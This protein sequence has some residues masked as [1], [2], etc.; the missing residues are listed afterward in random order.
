MKRIIVILGTIIM[1]FITYPVHADATPTFAVAKTGDSVVDPQALTLE[2]DAKT[3]W[4]MTINGLS[5]QQDAILSHRGYQYVGYYDADRYVCL[6]RR[7]L[8]DGDWKIIRFDDYRF[9]GNDTHNT[10]SVGICPQDGTIHLAF[11]HHVSPLHY[12]VSRTGAANHPDKAAWNAALFGPVTSE[13]KGLDAP[14][15]GISYPRFIQTPDGALQLCFRRGGSGNGSNFLIDYDPTTGTWHD[16]RQFLSSQGEY[17]DGGATSPSR[18]A[19][20]NGIDYG[21]DGKL[22]ISWVWREVMWA[23]NRDLSY[24]YSDDRGQTW[25]N[26]LGKT[27]PAPLTSDSPL[28]VAEIHRERKLMNTVSQ[29]VD[30]DGRAHVVVWHQTADTIAERREAICRPFLATFASTG[31]GQ[32]IQEWLNGESVTVAGDPVIKDTGA[33]GKQGFSVGAYQGGEY[34][35]WRGDIGEVLVYDRVLSDKDRRSVQAYLNQRWL[36]A[37]A[38]ESAPQNP[39]TPAGLRLWLTADRGVTTDADGRVSAWADQ[40]GNGFDISQPQEALQPRF[41]PT[42]INNRPSVAFANDILVHAGKPLVEPGSP[43]TVFIIARS[44]E[45]PHKY[46]PG[47]GGDLFAFQLGGNSMVLSQ[48]QFYAWWVIYKDGG[49]GKASAKLGL[50]GSGPQSGFGGWPGA[51]RYQHY[52]RNPETGAWNHAE[53]PWIPGDRPKLFADDDNNLFM[54]FRQPEEL[55]DFDEFKGSGL[56]GL[57]FSRGRLVIAGATAA[58]KWKDWRILHTEP[59]PFFNEML[60]DNTRWREDGILSIM[61]QD[62]PPAKPG[63]P[64]PLRILDFKL[65]GT[66]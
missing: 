62:A 42:G 11:D 53:L 17:S 48:C 52:W 2:E 28:V 21:P 57:F 38:P 9:E 39:P 29:T 40:S 3:P 7:E 25:K 18:G 27:V 64:T 56:K 32:P 51:R 47:W 8:P 15:L 1:V 12:R 66:P 43:R 58:A 45:E 37:A 65:G 4:G 13:L 35:G 41:N 22:H 36:Q 49:S 16:T 34:I 55:E 54:I 61:V 30:R 44:V 5:F 6:A 59:G 20:L 50:A 19:Y 60:G 23:Q 63:T 14:V 46:G 24:A 33:P 10:I 31:A 26:T